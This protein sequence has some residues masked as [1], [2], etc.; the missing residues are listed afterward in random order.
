[1]QKKNYKGTKPVCQTFRGAWSSVEEAASKVAI[2]AI[3]AV[4]EISTEAGD[5]VLD[6]VTAGHF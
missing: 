6:T 2:G 3:K 1:L 4:Y 5:K